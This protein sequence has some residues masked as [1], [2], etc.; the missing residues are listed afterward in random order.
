M[1]KAKTLE[2]GRR[3]GFCGECKHF[4]SSK[5][6]CRVKSPTAVMVP[7]PDGNVRV[8]GIW[9]AVRAEMWCAEFELD[10]QIA[11]DVD[12]RAIARA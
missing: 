1:D 12:L 6:E 8:L 10:L 4:A 7:L 11:S 3:P 2:R 5:Q 9:P